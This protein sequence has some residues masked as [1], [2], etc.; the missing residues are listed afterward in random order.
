MGEPADRESKTEE[1]TEK[2]LSDAIARGQQAF[3]RELPQ[4]AS[5]GAIWLSL[6]FLLTGASEKIVGALLPFWEWPG[7]WSLQTSADAAALVSYVAGATLLPLLPSA[8]LICLAGVFGSIAQSRGF[9]VERIKPKTSRISPIAG[10]RRLFGKDG[11]AHVVKSTIGLIFVG[12]IAAF[13]LFHLIVQSHGL[14]GI[15]PAGLTNILSSMSS[16]LLFVMLNAMLVIAVIDLLLTRQSWR[17]GLRMTRHEVKEE[18]KD[19][20]G[21]PQIKLRMRMIARRRARTNMLAAVPRATVVITN[22]THYAVAL[23]YVAGETPA[24]IVVAKGAD[25]VALRIRT[26]AVNCGIPIVEDA[27]LARAVHASAEVDSE[28]PPALYQ[29]VARVIIFLDR[30]AMRT[31]TIR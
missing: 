16:H 10:W 21:D 31:K 26:A 17:Q 24:P 25:L 30:A 3:T 14:I 5:A 18:S 27:P 29:A 2:K 6:A 11:L 15:D 19:V 22:P 28:I 8:L 1:A 9:A 12:S 7:E 13:A 23:R 20:D 4:L